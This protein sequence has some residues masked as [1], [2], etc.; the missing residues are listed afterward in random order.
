MGLFDRLTGGGAIELTP[1]SSLALSAIVMM[2][3]DGVVEE[4][5][6]ASLG[7]IVRDDKKAFQDAYKVYKNKKPSEIIPMV[8]EKLN[9]RQR[10]AT[11]AILLDMAM[12]DGHLDNNEK[13]LLQAFADAFELAE[14]D[15]TEIIDVIAIKNNFSIFEE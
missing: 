11:I 5:E 10:L 15:V 8:A 14:G 7:Q 3:A 2:A 4:S 1:K 12:G 9:Q 6:L 13:A